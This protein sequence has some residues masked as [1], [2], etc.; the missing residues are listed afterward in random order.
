VVNHHYLSRKLLGDDWKVRVAWAWSE[1]GILLLALLW[2]LTGRGSGRLMGTIEGQW[3]LLRGRAAAPPT[4][5]DN[6][7]ERSEES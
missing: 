4:E 3:D 6:I 1:F 2:W 5:A 7:T